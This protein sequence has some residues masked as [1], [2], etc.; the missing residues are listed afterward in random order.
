PF[1]KIR[2]F[3]LTLVFFLSLVVCAAA[4]GAD[5]SRPISPDQPLT[6]FEAAVPVMA[7][8]AESQ[9]LGFRDA[10]SLS[11]SNT[12]YDMQQ[13]GSMGFQ[14]VVGNG[15]VHNVWNYLPGASNSN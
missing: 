15:W 1:H 14:I 6:G 7:G 13:N 3:R 5:L 2:R 9:F 4:P 12:W 10:N 11:I 8:S